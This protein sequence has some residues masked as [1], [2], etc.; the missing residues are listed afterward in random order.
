MSKWLHSIYTDRGKDGDGT[1]DEVVCEVINEVLSIPGVQ[2][3]ILL[4]ALKNSD[5]SPK[6]DGI[7]CIADIPF[8]HMWTIVL[9]N[10]ESGG[11]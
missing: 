6:Y 4:D 3:A 8:R 7:E 1:I 5:M 2:E 11:K 9:S 10:D